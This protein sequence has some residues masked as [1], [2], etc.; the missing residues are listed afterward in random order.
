MAW[1]EN[2]EIAKFE[3]GCGADVWD[4]NSWEGSDIGRGAGARGSEM[5]RKTDKEGVRTDKRGMRVSKS[6][7]SVYSSLHIEANED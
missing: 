3:N 1:P 6:W 4:K 5:R 7:G 2:G